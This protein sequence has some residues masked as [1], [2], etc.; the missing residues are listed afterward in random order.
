MPSFGKRLWYTG[1]MKSV[2]VRVAGYTIV[3]VMIFLAVSGVIF[4]MAAAF[5]NGKQANTEY[6]QSVNDV[7]TQLQQV[8]DNVR[9]G[10]YPTKQNFT[11]SS[12]GSPSAPVLSA[13]AK[14]EGTNADCIY[15]GEVV[16][17]GVINP[18]GSDTKGSGYNI[19]PVIG[20]RSITDVSSGVPLDVTSLA[21]A[22]PTPLT[23]TYTAATKKSYTLLYGLYVTNMYLMPDKQKISGFGVF[24]ELGSYSGGLLSSGA[25]GTQ[26]TTIPGLDYTSGSY[27]K[28]YKTY[29]GSNSAS[30]DILNMA[31]PVAHPYTVLS[32]SQYITICLTAGNGHKASV[33]LGNNKGDLSVSPQM[34]NSVA[35]VCAS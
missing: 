17:F 32:S 34:G 30:S 21:E 14:P 6:A 35:G 18:D 22:R 7:S 33:S 23:P 31:D 26:L 11:C 3:E 20:N 4:V 28:G 1:N 24:S 9:N 13:G 2:G 29:T 25:Q 15:L 5:I 10:Y 8:L 19:I 27:I 16:Q 12:G